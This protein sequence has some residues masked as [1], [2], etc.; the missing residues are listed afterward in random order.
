MMHKL[1]CPLCG[2]YSHSTDED[3]FAPCPHC[4]AVFSEKYGNN[5]RREERV[6]QET[7]FVFSWQGQYLKANTIDISKEGLRIKIFSG[8]AVAAGDIMDFS[9]GNLPIKAI[10]MWVDNLSDESMVGLQRLN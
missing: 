4:G 9:L 3:I 8:S 1:L 7:S 5:K 6:K 2:K 10:V